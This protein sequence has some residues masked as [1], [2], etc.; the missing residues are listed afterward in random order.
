MQR[1][2]WKLG[3]AKERKNVTGSYNEEKPKYFLSEIHKGL[4]TFQQTYGF[5]RRSAN[6][7]SPDLLYA[8]SLRIDNKTDSENERVRRS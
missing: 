6:V 4:K 8:S 5:A 3:K 7:G 2:D 1:C